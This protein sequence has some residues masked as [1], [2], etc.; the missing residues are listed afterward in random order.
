MNEQTLA[1]DAPVDE[2]T[3]AGSAHGHAHGSGQ[4][5]EQQMCCDGSGRTADQ[6][7]SESEDGTCCVDK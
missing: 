3:S 6:H 2:A 7:R 5:A 4:H 1:Q